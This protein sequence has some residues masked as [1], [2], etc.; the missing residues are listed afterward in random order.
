MV[1]RMP[2][3]GAKPS[4]PD[5]RDHLSIVHARLELPVAPR[6]VDLRAQGP[7]V[8]DQ[9]QLGSC[10]PHGWLRAYN[11]AQRRQGENLTSPSALF[12]Y[13]VGRN[14]E[15]TVGYDSGLEIRDGGKAIGREGVAD[16]FVWPYDIS[17]FTERPADAA[18]R[19]ADTH[20]ALHYT[21][22][23]DQRFIHNALQIRLP[24]VM[25][26]SV[27]ES[28]EAT[29]SDGM[30]PIPSTRDSIIGGHCMLIEG[31]RLDLDAFIVANS[32]SNTWGDAGYCYF[33]AHLFEP[34][35]GIVF[36]NDL[37][38]LERVS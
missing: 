20:L 35:R 1:R 9:G 15:G 22:L 32:W 23:R 19:Q 3:Y 18:W 31:Y 34:D 28:F 24:V 25:G 14:L 26:F 21:R 13:W 5:H 7:L 4:L 29:G 17:R 38:T 8:W 10:V 6:D 33:P 12:T 36:A 30:V 11:H 37:W 2:F 16:R 27:F